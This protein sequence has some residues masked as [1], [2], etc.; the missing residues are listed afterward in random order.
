MH[1][2]HIYIHNVYIYIYIYIYTEIY[3]YTYTYLLLMYTDMMIL[4]AAEVLAVLDEELQMLK[5]PERDK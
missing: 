3:T 2:I 4:A 5:D 1:Y